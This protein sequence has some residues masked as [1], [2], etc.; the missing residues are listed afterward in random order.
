MKCTRLFLTCILITTVL[1]LNS[2]TQP[3]QPSTYIFP[4]PISNTYNDILSLQDPNLDKGDDLSIIASLIDAKIDD[5]HM[6][7]CRKYVMPL[8]TPVWK[9]FLT[10]YETEMAKQGWQGKP[11]KISSDSKVY[12]LNKES[13]TGIMAIY[14]PRF[15]RYMVCTFQP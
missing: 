2:C 13:K 6:S 1:F 4:E 8:P 3:D 15:S 14:E 12:W 10:H 5:W 11:T 7:Q 9:D